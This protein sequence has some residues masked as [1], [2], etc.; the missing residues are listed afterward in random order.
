MK[1]WESGGYAVR[2]LRITSRTY[3]ISTA[4]WVGIRAT[5]KRPGRPLGAAP[6]APPTRRQRCAA[7]DTACRRRR[8]HRSPD[9]PQTGGGTT[10][11]SIFSSLWLRPADGHNRWSVHLGPSINDVWISNTPPHLDSK[12]F[13]WI[14]MTMQQ[15]AF[16]FA[17]D[18]LESL[19][20]F[21]FT[22]FWAGIT[23]YYYP[24]RW[25]VIIS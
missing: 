20:I 8:T 10:L 11:H 18:T 7:C 19:H 13:F 22:E 24:S 6:H 21:Y 17:S 12:H 14:H 2:A 16:D 25:G 3:R 9:E 23:G 15:V 4:W 5:I 1:N